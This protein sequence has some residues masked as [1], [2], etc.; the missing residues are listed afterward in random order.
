MKS[1]GGQQVVI[2]IQRMSES[3]INVI[4]EFG[5]QRV[6]ILMQRTSESL[7]IAEFRGSKRSHFDAAH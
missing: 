2:L 4:E 1:L 5:G 7:I 3:L 6:V